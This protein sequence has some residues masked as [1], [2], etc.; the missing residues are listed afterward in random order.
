MRMRISYNI[1][2][3]LQQDDPTKTSF[4]LNH[5]KRV[6]NHKVYNQLFIGKSSVI[7]S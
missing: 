3:C 6:N 7:I 5:E 4:R 2:S 1:C